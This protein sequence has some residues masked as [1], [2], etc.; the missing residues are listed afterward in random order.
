METDPQMSQLELSQEAVRPNADIPAP[1]KTEAEEDALRADRER[2]LQKAWLTRLTAEEKEHEDFRDRGGVV[3]KIFEDD[4]SGTDG[5]YVPLL[6]SVVQVE[7]S[8]VYSSQ[9]TP[10]VRPNNEDQNPIFKEAATVLER[11]IT[12]YADQQSF[13]DN[14]HRVVDDYLV[15]GLGVPRIKLRSEIVQMPQQ[16]Q[17]MG[18]MGQPGMPQGGGTEEAVGN[19]T[20]HW[21]Y[22]PWRRFGWEPCNSWDSCDWI[23]FRHPMTQAQ[24]KKRFGRSVKA[25]K[26]TNKSGGDSDWQSKTYDIYEIWDKANRKIVFLAK[27]EPTPLEVQKDPL[28]LAGFYPMPPP[29]LTN[30]ESERLMPIPDYNYIEP[31]DVEINDLQERRMALLEQLRASGAYDE[32]FP[33]LGTILSLGDGEMKPIK[34]LLSRLQGNGFDNTMFFLPLEEKIAVINQLTEQIQFVKA[35]VDEILGIADIV[36]GVSNAAEGVGTQE[37]KGRWV[38][39][40]LSRKRDVVQYTVREMFRIM[41]QVLSSHY[42]D[43]NLTRLTQMQINPEV[44]KLLRNDLM[45]DFSIDIEADSTVVKDEFAERTSRREMMEGLGAYAQAVLP[46]VQQGMMPADVSSAVL[47]AALTPYTKYDRGL[48]EALGKLQT[49]E[50]QLG[51]MRQQMQQI[52]QELQQTKQGLQ[53]WQSIAQT[54]QYQST[55]AASRQKTAD[56]GKKVAETEKIRAETPGEITKTTSE[57]QK[58]RAQVVDILRPEPPRAPG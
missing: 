8:G 23:Y 18:Q 22:V 26:D 30:L 57:T 33:E 36:R 25:S 10:D 44:T 43:E 5:L 47:R 34:N 53:H 39:I 13:D 31:Y 49:T 54:L 9:P 50:Q 35:Q 19:Q 52:Q 46:M 6:W 58:N 32:G 20:M 15:Q 24:I 45:M 7:H 37:L 29:M 41:G 48:D 17:Q 4:N 12:Y 56:A 16:S 28:G 1:E 40:R 2:A 42:T 3:Q 21:E 51:Q 11:G 27:G 55:E 38:G 14:F